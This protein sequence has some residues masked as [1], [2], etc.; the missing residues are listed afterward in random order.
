MIGIKLINSSKYAKRLITKTAFLVMLIFAITLVTPS[1][2]S[3]ANSSN[4]IRL[5][6]DILLGDGCTGTGKDVD[7]YAG[8]QQVTLSGPSHQ[9]TF[10]PNG[11][12]ETQLIC[13][14]GLP[15]C[16]GTTEPY[17]YLPPT[18]FNT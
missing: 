8:G 10:Y 15:W 9:T 13:H 7:A 14:P 12:V 18:C 17:T 5:F 2:I 3:Y 4:N 11:S 1:N 16:E 6:V